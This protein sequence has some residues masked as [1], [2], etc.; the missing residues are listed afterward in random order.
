MSKQLKKQKEEYFMMWENC[1]KFTFQYPKIKFYW[2]ML[3]HLFT[4]CLWLHLYYS[5]V[6]QS[7]H[8]RDH[9]SCRCWSFTEKVFANPCS[10]YLKKES[11]HNLE[12]KTVIHYCINTSVLED[13]NPMQQNLVKSMRAVFINELENRTTFKQT[14]KS[15][16]R[17]INL[18]QF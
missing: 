6:E 14:N 9:M 15:S 13:H 16:H 12:Y 18:M 5:A 2:D 11:E 1:M 17:K 3:I 8:D 7:I 10:I 4:R